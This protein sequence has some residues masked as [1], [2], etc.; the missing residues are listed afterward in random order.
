MY[1][2]EGREPGVNVIPNG[3]FSLGQLLSKEKV[4]CIGE[5]ELGLSH[6]NPITMKQGCGPCGIQDVGL[7]L[8]NAIGPGIGWLVAN[9]V[10]GTLTHVQRERAGVD[11]RSAIESLAPIGREIRVPVLTCGRNGEDDAGARK[12]SPA[13]TLAVSGE[14]VAEL[15]G[16]TVQG[17]GGGM[18]GG[19]GT[20]TGAGKSAVDAEAGAIHGGSAAGSESMHGDRLGVSEKFLET[21]R[22]A[23]MGIHGLNIDEGEIGN[24]VVM[25]ADEG[26]SREREDDIIFK[27]AQLKESE[28]TWNLAVES[29]VELYDED[30]DIMSILQAENAKIAEK[31]K[32]AKQKEKARRSRPKNKCKVRNNLVK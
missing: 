29:S 26:K 5:H 21:T 32:L 22:E 25:E 18:V 15:H 8:G 12:M 23:K 19:C 13:L 3:S 28:V 24:G 4:C 1:T 20:V 17:S 6:L 10:T 2:E 30:V 16:V 27:E 14:A 31:R 11:G 9:R 7:D